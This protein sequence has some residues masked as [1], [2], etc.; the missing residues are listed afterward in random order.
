MSEGDI[1]PHHLLNLKGPQLFDQ[2][3]SDDETDQ[4]GRQDCIDRPEGDIPKDIKKSE[5]FMK[6]IE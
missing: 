5:I 6:R 1:L 4:K 2:P 3:G